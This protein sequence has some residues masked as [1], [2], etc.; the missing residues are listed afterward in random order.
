MSRSG[1][2][3]GSNYDDHCEIRYHA[4]RQAVSCAI[5]GKRGQAFLRELKVALNTLPTQE[6][7]AGDFECEG[8]YCALGAIAK[9]RGLDL[10]GLDAE[11][12]NKVGRAF[13]IAESMA[14]EITY[15]N[16]EDGG[17]N[18]TPSRRWIRVNKWVLA[19]IKGAQ[20]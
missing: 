1:Y 11:D 18:E 2:G 8:S 10:A 5:E 4:Y 3:D 13:G 20:Q 16:D 7:I 17:C 6:L 9:A 12:A 15:V 19:N 14:R